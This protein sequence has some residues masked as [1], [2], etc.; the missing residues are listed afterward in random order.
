LSLLAVL[1]F[2]FTLKG[3]AMPTLQEL[4]DASAALHHHLCPRQVLGVRMGMLAGRLLELDL[5]QK[6]K[7]LLTIMETDGC[8]TNGVAVATGCWVGRR[9]LRVEDFG[10]V[11]A[12]FVDRQSEAQQTSERAIRIAPRPDVRRLVAAYAPEAESRWQAYLLGYQRMPDDLLF[13]WQEVVL[14]TPLQT[15]LSRPGMRTVCQIC[16]EEIMNEREVLVEGRVLCRS[17]AGSAYYIAPPR[18]DS[19]AQGGLC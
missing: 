8:A 12:T 11:A 19:Q 5:P 2:R 4:L 9:T 3:V 10:K 13:S 17:C 6:N 14:V 18:Y 7:R 1:L 16:R 15:I